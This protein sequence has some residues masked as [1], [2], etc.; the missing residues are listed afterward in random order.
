MRE[1]RNAAFDQLLRAETQPPEHRGDFHPRLAE[2]V[3][4]VDRE[5]LRRRW[6]RRHLRPLLIAAVAAAVALT[7]VALFAG[8]SSSG[9]DVVEMKAIQRTIARL[10]VAKG[11]ALA[12]QT[13]D[14]ARFETSPT[15]PE[16]L[17][18][19]MEAGW[20]AALR[21]LGTAEFVA[22]ENE[23]GG[24]AVFANEGS[25]RN[26]D[27][28]VRCET[29]VV[30]VAYRRTLPDGDVV[31]WAEVWAG[32]IARLY[33]SGTVG[34]GE[35]HTV[36]VDTTPTYQYQLRA[37]DG[38]WRIVAEALVYSSEDMSGDYGPDTPHFVDSQRLVS[39][40][41]GLVLD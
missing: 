29:E 1:E 26:G 37:V 17:K 18:D 19:E 15:L 24:S 9:P 39:G 12:P 35:P 32:E 20:Q 28:I 14:Y 13:Q 3:E 27:V 6:G 25:R 4:A 7:V 40:D 23:G 10:W 11:E 5:R 22:K 30:D 8:G 33:Q 41:E 38:G 36:R 2:G 21:S 34:V 16:G 31:V